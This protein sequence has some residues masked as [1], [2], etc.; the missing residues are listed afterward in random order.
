MQDKINEIILE[1][2]AYF[3]LVMVVISSI[4]SWVCLMWHLIIP[5]NQWFLI[6]EQIGG[7]A[8]V[9]LITSLSM[10]AIACHKYK[11]NDE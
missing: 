4:V 1:I 5:I 6:R 7:C 2:I 11:K 8:A 3:F 9:F 10:I